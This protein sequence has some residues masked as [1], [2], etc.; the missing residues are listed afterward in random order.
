M[1][2]LSDRPNGVVG[3][4]RADVA[5]SSAEGP[6]ESE[7]EFDLKDVMAATRQIVFET[8]K[9]EQSNFEAMRLKLIAGD[10]E[11]KPALTP[12]EMAA[13]YAAKSNK[14]ATKKKPAKSSAAAA[15]PSPSKVDKL[16]GEVA[17]ASAIET[18]VAGNIGLQLL[19]Q[20]RLK[21]LEA[22]AQGV[23]A[24]AA[25]PASDAAADAVAVETAAAHVAVA[26]AAA[27]E[28]AAAT[29]AFEEEA[30]KLAKAADEAKAVAQAAEVAA[31]VKA[32]EVA[33]IEAAEA[34]AAAE[35]KAAPK[36]HVRYNHKN[37]AFPVVDGRLDFSLVDAAYCISYVLKGQW[38]CRLRHET[39]GEI[40]LDAPL[41]IETDDIGDPIA[42]GTFSGLQLHGADGQGTTTE[43]QYTLLVEQDASQANAPRE[44]YRGSGSNGAG[45]GREGSRKEG[46]SCLWGNPCA[47]P[48]H[49]TD[50]HNRYEVAKRNVRCASAALGGGCS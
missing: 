41:K 17:Q 42:R 15:K 43:A 24:P 38:V 22:P 23:A 30:A 34:S 12:A 35:A 21:A 2:E 14:K 4:L 13:N 16:R 8:R 1:E 3:K 47:S 33:A 31:K 7:P 32:E 10:D 40:A 25:A 29:K 37:S 48:E 44:A 27:A 20:A 50:W 46:C 39:L 28:A 5:S 9:K 19:Q 45:L 36:V 11:P 26:E 18:S 49:C 6:S